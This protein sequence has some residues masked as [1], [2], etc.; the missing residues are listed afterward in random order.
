M[1]DVLWS[2][3][4]ELWYLSS[5]QRTPRFW[6]N[7]PSAPFHR[8]QKILTQKVDK[9]TT[10]AQAP[11]HKAHMTDGSFRLHVIGL[12][13]RRISHCN[14]FKDGQKEKTKSMRTLILITVILHLKTRDL[15]PAW[16][17]P[18]RFDISGVCDGL[19]MHILQTIETQG[20]DRQS[21]DFEI[22]SSF[23]SKDN[24]LCFIFKPALSMVNPKWSVLL[25]FSFWC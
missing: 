22:W 25:G 4:W 20:R 23:E 11:T 15:L 7:F 6:K 3:F 8:K 19:S 5:Q 10:C 14:T 2:L 24:S 9:H 17:L 21:T 12:S 13:T 18:A 16:H 1:Q